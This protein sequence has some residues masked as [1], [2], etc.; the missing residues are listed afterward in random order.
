MSDPEELRRA[1]QEAQDEIARLR[2]QLDIAR[3]F[4][5]F[6][7]WER[8]IP[9]DRGRWDRQ[10]FE[11]FGLDPADG[12]PGHDR[13]RE[14]I[15]PEDA[16]NRVYPDSTRQAGRYERR[17]R[18]VRRDG[19]V[20]WIHS[21][22]VV[23][24][25]PDGRP[26]RS[27]G[28]MVDDTET[29]GLAR[30]LD[31]ATAQ[32]K[33]AVE[34]GN[35]AIWR[36][37]LKSQR[38]YY[39]ER[40]FAVLGIPTRPEGLSIDEVR[41][42]IHPDDL[43]RVIESA[44]IALD[45]DRPTDMEA[46]YR[47]SDGS[48]RHVLTRRV[49][50]RDALGQ[51]AAFLGVALDVTEQV[52][53]RREAA[54][55]A[56]RLET[57]A[58]A[59]GIGVWRVDLDAN[60]G[61]WNAQMYRIAG[62]NPADGWPGADAWWNQIVHPED[63]EAFRRHENALLRTT[64]ELHEHMFRVTRGD[65]E[66]RWLVDRAV[67]EQVDGRRVLQGVTLDVTEQQRTELAL[68]EANERAAL[69]AR[70]AGIGT[71]Q[72]D[73]QTGEGQWDEQMWRLRGLEP[74]P[75]A[76]G[77]QE[78]MALV[79]PDDRARLERVTRR[80]EAKAGAVNAEFRVVW[81]D[82]QWRWIASRSV[83]TADDSGRPLR[84]LGVNWDVTEAR[85]AE[86]ARQEKAL[87]ER[88]SHAKSQFL[89][90]MSHELRTPLN[91]VLGFAQ[92]LEH[93]AGQPIGETQLAKIGHIRR[94]GAHLLSLIDDVLELTRLESGAIAL[95]RRTVSLADLVGQALPLVA[96]LAAQRGVRLESQGNKALAWADR[97]RTL[98]VALNLLSN[99]IKYNHEGGE[100]RVRTAVRGDHAILEVQD[101]GRGLEP[102]EVAHL[103]EPFNRLHAAQSEV[104]GTGI[105]LVIV[106]ALVERMHG[107]V[108]VESRIGEGTRV[109]V[110]LPA[111]DADAAE[112][113]TH[114]GPLQ[115][116]D[117]PLLHGSLLY[118]EDNPV[119]V[120]LLEEIVRSLPAIRFAAELSGLAGVQRAQSWRPDLIL[121][122]MQLPDIDGAQVLSRLKDA[123]GTAS[124]PC[125]A[126]SANAMPE[127]IERALALG[128]TDY[129]TKP[130]DVARVRAA[131][132]QR[133][134]AVE[135]RTVGTEAPAGS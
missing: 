108:E 68:R 41:S 117:H 64:G 60:V 58:A 97:R 76:L 2:E 110:R 59:A 65:G 20:R 67:C 3:D 13:A 100:V 47:R 55:L 79:H 123:P 114:P 48:W 86:A 74:R 42:F 62:R 1:L 46:R 71:W 131:L 85:N 40:A 132:A 63:R 128:F 61:E 130:I 38:M 106:K 96:P 37:D 33:L 23:K 51:P 8:E 66:V 116:V 134:S 101:S 53:K 127:D 111:S 105:G 93:E 92:L 84:V 107:S 103:F 4:G 50:Q 24:N 18:I 91:A 104:E 89:A 7:L 15:H 27:V 81:P 88:E 57:A 17:Y 10:I 6:G 80:R 78:R 102:E 119:N 90:R 87:A 45:S 54:Q 22:W 49:V 135:G 32:L 30:S 133:F 75:G 5:R 9:S 121:L 118:I 34:L 31:D 122:D 26:A 16:G 43:P 115:T 72:Y 109:R 14:L 99:A 21:Q 12:T 112:P 83:S 25:G 82:G 28:V 19:T 39:N 95:E 69:A 73:V 56:R 126:V 36:H 44:R 124:I 98:Q 52:E 94:A 70:G 35:I 125:I 11:F 113:D 77:A 29:L 129:W 120:T